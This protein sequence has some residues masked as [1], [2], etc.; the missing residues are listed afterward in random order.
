LRYSLV[1]D[2]YEKI[3]ATTKRLEMTDHLVELLR[4]TPESAIDK[5]VYLTQ[6]KLHPDFTGIEIGMAEKL[7]IKAV[8]KAAGRKEKDIEED[9]EKTGDLGETTQKFLEKRLQ[10]TFFPEPL[11][12]ERVYSTLDRVA[13]ASGTGSLDQ[14]INLLVGLLADAK[15]A[16]AKYIIR[17]V[18]GQLRL[19]IADMT[20]LDALAIAYGGSKDSRPILERAYNGS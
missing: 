12:V 17:T 13:K 1:A 4:N 14:K 2:A 19:G 20:V 6:G 10:V 8:A 15:P 18:T 5:V 16:E 11:S 3:G 7:A 9:I